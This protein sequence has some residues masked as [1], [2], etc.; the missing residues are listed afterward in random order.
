M[1][2]TTWIMTMR[3][4]WFQGCFGEG[5]SFRL[6]VFGR[7]TA[8]N[9]LHLSTSRVGSTKARAAGKDRSALHIAAGQPLSMDGRLGVSPVK[10]LV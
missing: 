1:G 5:L 7:H 9:R 6:Q 2:E 10:M 8:I 3:C 4:G